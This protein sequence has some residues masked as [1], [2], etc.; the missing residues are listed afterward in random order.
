MFY[1][2]AYI[3]NFTVL[4]PIDNTET[5]DIAVFRKL[6]M[7]VPSYAVTHNNHWYI[8]STIQCIGDKE[9]LGNTNSDVNF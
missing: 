7:L 1:S 9:S 3:P 4:K 6:S 8:I 5:C 2:L